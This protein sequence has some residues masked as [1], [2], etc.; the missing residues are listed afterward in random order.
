MNDYFHDDQ[1]TKELRQKI[2]QGKAPEF[3]PLSRST[4]TKLKLSGDEGLINWKILRANAHINDF[5]S[6]GQRFIH[7]DAVS[8]SA[9]PDG[10]GNIVIK[11][12]KVMDLTPHFSILIGEAAYQLRTCLEHI[13]F[14]IVKPSTDA[15]KQ[16]TQFPLYDTAR[17]F[18]SNFDRRM[19]NVSGEVKNLI[20]S[21]QPY[22][23]GQEKVAEILWRLQ[24]INNWD[25]HRCFAL[26]MLSS[27]GTTVDVRV[28]GKVI[29]REI[30]TGEFKTGQ[31]LAT[32]KC[33]DLA[34]DSKIDA[35]IEYIGEPIFDNGMSP[36][37]AGES[38]ADRLYEAVHVMRKEI[39]PMFRKFF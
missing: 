18:N 13:A 35:D 32:I 27:V 39:V 38:C 6:S 36:E 4:S 12:D 33:A 14:M 16:S 11:A 30:Y 37:F 1:E 22:Q 3:T 29:G 5:V 20:S 31:V 26:A 8:L 19:P 25:K 15:E 10:N 23:R 21:I 9:K 2:Q 24:A 28:D 17:K 34:V 7:S